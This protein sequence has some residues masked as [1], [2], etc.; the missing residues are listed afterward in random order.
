MEH[1]TKKTVYKVCDRLWEANGS[2]KGIASLFSLT[3]NE[4]YFEK[5]EFIGISYMLNKIG[6]ELGILEDILRS[7][8]DNSA[9]A[10]YGLALD[11]E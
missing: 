6:E 3:N 5:E 9:N 10:R 11:E 1:L 2:L 7:G 4:V 8:K